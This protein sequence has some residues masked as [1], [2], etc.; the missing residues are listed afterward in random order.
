M[1]RKYNN[2]RRSIFDWFTLDITDLI[3]AVEQNDPAEVYRAL[4]ARVNPNRRDGI[5]RLPLPIAV[6]NNNAE[7]V[8]MLLKAKAD[9]NRLD[10]SGESPLYKAVFWNN[11][12]IVKMLLQAGAKPSLPNVSGVTPIDEA[13]QNGY[14]EILSLLDQQ[15]D[16]AEAKRISSERAKHEA[17]RKKAESERQRRV[18]S[19]E[20]KKAQ[21]KKEQEKAAR[22]KLKELEVQYKIKDNNYLRGLLRAMNQKDSVATKSFAERVKDINAYDPAFKTTPLMMAV[23]QQNI[24]LSRFLLEKGANPLGQV[25]GSEYSPFS[26]AVL[27]GF[28]DFVKLASEYTD[29]EALQAVMNDPDQV[30]SPQL[31]AY[32]DARMLDLLLSSGADAHFGGKDMPSPV[33]KAIEKASVAILPV[34]QRNRVDLNQKTQ[35]RTPLDWAV[36]HRRVDWVNGLIEEG[37]DVDAVDGEGKTALIRAVEENVPEIV[38]LLLEA[39]ADVS[40]PN[41]QGIKAVELA[42]HLGDR[43]EIYQML[44]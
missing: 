19:A 24:K 34:L 31:L 23:N 30:M 40:I 29:P 33:V 28:F 5:R 10:D 22:R 32:K 35:G 17:I 38:Q 36:H 8:E 20:Q 6:N 16:K 13:S 2:P 4:S 27:Q 26:K 12:P 25:P 18:K 39:G 3:R 21:E 42:E 37:V 9:P 11:V 1:S 44:K 7:I 14:Q 43:D 41:A 15:A